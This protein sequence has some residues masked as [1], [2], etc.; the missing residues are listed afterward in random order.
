MDDESWDLACSAA[1]LRSERLHEVD[2]MIRTYK[3]DG[4]IARGMW[5]AGS[6][7]RHAMSAVVRMRPHRG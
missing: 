4:P 2:E 7:A 5:P 3:E 6:E 1:G